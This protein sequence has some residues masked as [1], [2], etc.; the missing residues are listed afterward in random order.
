MDRTFLSPITTNRKVPTS[1]IGPQRRV[2]VTRSEIQAGLALGL[3]YVT[4]TDLREMDLIGYTLTEPKSTLPVSTGG[5]AT[6]SHNFL[7]SYDIDNTTGAYGNPVD[8]TYTVTALAHGTVLLNG[9]VTTTFTQADIDIGLVQYRQNGDGAAS[10]EFTF[11]VSDVA[12]NHMTEPFSIAIINTA[13]PVIK[14]N[15]K[16]AASTGNP[17]TVWQTTRYAQ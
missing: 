14:S 1:V 5:T 3:A 15:E 6:V 10:D 9:S 2:P 13:A 7:W 16:L 8:V 12:G 4:D 17:A 11:T